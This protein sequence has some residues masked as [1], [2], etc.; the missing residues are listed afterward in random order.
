MTRKKGK[1]ENSQVA[2]VHAARASKVWSEIL[3]PI[4]LPNKR[5]RVDDVVGERRKGEKKVCSFWPWSLPFNCYLVTLSLCSFSL[6]RKEGK[7]ETTK[8]CG[9]RR[10]TRE[11]PWTNHF[12]SPLYFFLIARLN[13]KR[14][15]KKKRAAFDPIDRQ[16]H[17]N[18]TTI[19]LLLLIDALRLTRES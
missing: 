4:F 18:K 8:T 14:T 7:I 13:R 15:G 10:L 12:N 16:K 17:R 1:I 19:P 6:E 11:I 9:E 2:H 5:R 3:F